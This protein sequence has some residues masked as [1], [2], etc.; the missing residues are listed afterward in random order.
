MAL[1]DVQKTTIAFAFGMV[2]GVV[3]AAVFLLSYYIR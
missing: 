2:A 3:V 1:S